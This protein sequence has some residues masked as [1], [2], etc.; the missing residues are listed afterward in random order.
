[1]KA[2]GVAVAR[3]QEHSWV[4]IP[5]IDQIVNV[6]TLLLVPPY[7]HGQWPMGWE[8]SSPAGT[9]GRGRRARSSPRSGKPVT[10]RR[11]SV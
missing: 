8:G 1:M 3:M 6:G 5:L 2:C 11:G 10:W 4:P 9:R 7:G